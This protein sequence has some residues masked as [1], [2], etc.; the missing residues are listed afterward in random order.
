MSKVYNP[1]LLKLLNGTIDF[2]TDTIKLL[3]VD[4][5][6]TFTK[7]HEFVSDIVANE[8]SGTGYSRK[9]LANADIL[10]DFANDR[11]KFDADDISYT[12]LD[13]GTIASAIIY[14]E[15]TNDADSPL[16]ADVDFTDLVTNGSDVDLRV[17]ADGFFFI[18]N[19]VT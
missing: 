9:T 15:V 6:H 13:A 5:N 12:A 18:T 3:L 1:G 16:I 14:K 4:T 17:N 19:D 7:S 8:A 10:E 2:D 11:V